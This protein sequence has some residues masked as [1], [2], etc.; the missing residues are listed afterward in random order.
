MAG[1][2]SPLEQTGAD[3]HRSFMTV[4]PDSTR[5]G[6]LV[7]AV[8]PA[9]AIGLRPFYLAAAIFA[10]AAVPV[11]VAAHS[12]LIGLD[13]Y[14]AGAAWHS[15]EMVFGFAPAVI[16][17]FLLTAARNWTGLPTPTGAMLAALVLLWAV[18]RVLVV[19]GPG[20]PA[21]I[22]DGLFLPSVALAVGLPIWKARRHRNLIVVAVVV[23]LSL[24]NLAFH[25][26]WIGIASADA[27]RFAPQLALDGIAILIA[28]IAGR[29]VPMFI[30]NAVPRARPRRVAA[31]EMAAIG[32]LVLVLLSD[33]AALRWPF[34]DAPLIVILIAAAVVHAVRLVLWAPFATRSEPLLWSLPLAYGW[35]PV[36][37]ALRASS[38]ISADVP[39]ALS[40]HALAVGAMAGLMLAMMSRSA[41]GH[42]GRALAAGPAE[43]SA[44]LLIQAAALLRVVPELVWPDT[45]PA[46][47]HLSAVCWSAAFL[48]WVVR[49]WP[50]LTRR[51][52]DGKPG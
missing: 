25:L 51:R 6:R 29:V 45:V 5:P 10:V 18:G 35:I 17:G 50:I 36:A 12:G 3:A 13:G 52:A 14:L 24:A 32:L 8:T 44:F 46:T 40:Q 31:I 23:A 9:F 16:A 33:L 34:G 15:H 42:T 19:T 47:L 48:V 2:S 11:W 27:V 1:G 37:L 21:L 38:M 20:I 43:T 7:E 4:R 30:A 26:G 39:P 49:Y 41:L 22:V 28:V